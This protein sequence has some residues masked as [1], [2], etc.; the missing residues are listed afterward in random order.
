M[1]VW[2]DV[3]TYINLQRHATALDRDKTF[4][5]FAATQWYKLYTPYIPM[6]YGMLTQVVS[7]KPFQI[8]HTVPYARAVYYGGRGG[9]AHF[10][11][12]LHPLATKEWSKAAQP[13]QKPK[14]MKTLQAYIDSGRAKL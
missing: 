3:K 6:R 2:V 5:T 1:S 12:E 9:N 14:L 11:R 10:R 4:G 7:I 8:T 13:M